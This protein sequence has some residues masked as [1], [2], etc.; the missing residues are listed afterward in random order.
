MSCCLTD[1]LMDGGLMKLSIW[2]E[3]EGR[4]E[5]RK[6]GGKE[7]R[8]LEQRRRQQDGG[9]DGWRGE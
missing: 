5:R 3:M 6:E 2:T 8:K 7:G 9:I 4:R 1:S